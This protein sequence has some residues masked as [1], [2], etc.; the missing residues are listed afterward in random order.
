MPPNTAFSVEDI[1]LLTRRYKIKEKIEIDATNKPNINKD[2][3]YDPK[4]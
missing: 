4:H 1:F 2:N 3:G